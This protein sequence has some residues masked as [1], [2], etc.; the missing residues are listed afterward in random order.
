MNYIPRYKYHRALVQ[1]FMEGLPPDQVFR[2]FYFGDCSIIIGGEF[3]EE[4]KTHLF[5]SAL[6]ENIPAMDSSK[7]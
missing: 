6:L 1:W 2:S 3:N 4:I 5:G 7:G